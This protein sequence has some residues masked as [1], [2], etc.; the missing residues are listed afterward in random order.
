[1]SNKRSIILTG[2][3]NPGIGNILFCKAQ[4]DTVKDRYKKILLSPDL[5]WLSGNRNAYDDQKN[6]IFGLMR[7]LFDDQ[8]YE[9]TDDQAYPE[10]TVLTF[11]TEDNILPVIPD[12]RK[13]LCNTPNP[14]K[15]KKYIVVTT[16]VRGIDVWNA[17]KGVINDFYNNIIRLSK[18]YEIVVMGERSIWMGLKKYNCIYDDFV[19][20]MGKNKYTDLTYTTG[21]GLH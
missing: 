4:L 21:N 6:F 20:Y 2:R 15:N 13:Y 11:M 17:Y 5:V 1:V 19:K 14:Y 10:R 12:I 8:P 7:L 3:L 16:K 18:R 9:V